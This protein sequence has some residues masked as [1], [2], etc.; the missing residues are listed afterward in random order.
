MVLILGIDPGTAIMGYGLVESGAGDSRD[1]AG[2]LRP[3]AERLKMVEYG[4]LLTPAN[5]PL[6]E[7]LPLLY[8]GL[9]KIIAEYKPQ[10][11]AIEELFFSKNA[12]T[13]ISVAHARGVAIL[14]GAHSE[15]S[16]AEYTPLQVKQAVVGYGKATKEQVQIMVKVLLNMDHIPR[17][18]DA[19]DA[20]AIAICHIHSQAYEDVLSRGQ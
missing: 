6:S 16:V 1:A 17:P 7:R 9:V 14:A 13:A 10:G 18:D 19:A 11:M 4:A 3:G 2:V 20:L 5:A 12:R 8:D 15:L